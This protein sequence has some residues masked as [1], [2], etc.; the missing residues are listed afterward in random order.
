MGFPKSRDR[1]DLIVLT[2]KIGSATPYLDFDC[3]W[4]SLGYCARAA[5]FELIR[6][7][8]IDEGTGFLI[9]RTIGVRPWKVGA[10]QFD[11]R[12]Y[13]VPYRQKRWHLSELYISARSLLP[14]RLA[15][16]THIITMCQY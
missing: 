4:E 10:E 14:H 13:E 9:K 11:R 7:W 5:L 8:A 2:K 1:L 6:N 16:F 3:R 12:S 15:D